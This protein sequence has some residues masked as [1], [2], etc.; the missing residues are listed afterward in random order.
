MNDAAVPSHVSPGIRIHTID[1][2]QPPG[3]CI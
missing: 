3:I 1:I 2:V